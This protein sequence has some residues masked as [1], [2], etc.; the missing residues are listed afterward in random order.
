MTTLDRY[1][2]EIET[3]NLLAEKEQSGLYTNIP[4]T[5]ENIEEKA[6]EIVSSFLTFSPILCR[7][8]DLMASNDFPFHGSLTGDFK[9]SYEMHA[10][11]VEDTTMKVVRKATKSYKKYLF[12]GESYEKKIQVE[13]TVPARKYK[14][15]IEY[16]GNY[17]YTPR[18]E[19]WLTYSEANTEC[20]VR[21]KAETGGYKK[22]AGF[23]FID[24]AQF[25]EILAKTYIS[26]INNDCKH[27]ELLVKKLDSFPNYDAIRLI[28]TFY[29]LKYIPNM[30]LNATRKLHRTLKERNKQCHASNST[31]TALKAPDI[32]GIT[33]E[34]EKIR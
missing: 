13:E 29:A 33:A 23:N 16:E 30:V 32:E 31:F 20:K 7:Q 4:L 9:I 1:I 6:R 21:F 19:F 8:I 26:A 3:A 15:F 18:D 27:E 34:I 5:T 12:F 28:R 11:Y 22:I 25:P 14:V 10:N 2:S 17:V 24:L